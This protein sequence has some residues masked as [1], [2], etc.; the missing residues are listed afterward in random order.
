MAFFPQL[1]PREVPVVDQLRI[2]D[3][4]IFEWLG[5]FTHPSVTNGKQIFRVFATPDRA[6]AEARNL[7]RKDANGG[8]DPTGTGMSPLSPIRTIPLPF[9]SIHR[10]TGVM[11]QQRWNR[12]P[13]TD[14][15]TAIV[16]QGNSQFGTERF[17]ADWPIPY[18]FPYQ[19]DVWT[20]N[21]TTRNYIEQWMAQQFDPYE[22]FLHTDFTTVHPAWGDKI[23]P[24]NY[25]S[26]DDLS[27]YEPG[28]PADRVIRY[29]LSVTAK[30]WL[31]RPVTV[32]KTVLTF[33]FDIYDGIPPSDTYLESFDIDPTTTAPVEEE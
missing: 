21:R 8:L 23:I 9:I 4:R 11:D 26:F 32:V 28:E 2:Y 15:G 31:F 25:E 29:S 14:L 6:F 16:D 24:I 19:I 27:D 1:S 17:I 30:G 20:R 10:A 18:N 3:Q 22:F 7:L 5:T 12:V 13:V 33:K